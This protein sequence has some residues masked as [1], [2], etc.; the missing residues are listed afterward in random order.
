MIDRDLQKHA[1]EFRG[2]LRNHKYDVTDDGILFP[3]AGAMAS[4]E[5]FFDTDGERPESS[6]NLIPSAA[7]EYILDVALG[8]TAAQPAWY[9]ALYSG[10]YTPVAGLTAASFS[11]SA[12]EIVSAVEGYSEVTRR[13][14]NA[15]PAAGGAKD[16]V[17][18]RAAFSIKTAGSITI[19][20]AALVS[21]S[22]K[23]G[24]S[25]ILVSAS[26]FTND[27]VE[28]DG[29]VFNLGYR[30]RIRSE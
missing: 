24:T 29:N 19:R 2:Y 7:L 23:G 20:G 8:A 10:A 14:W 12:T 5:Y 17:A 18:D 1:A 26:R 25:G 11:S 15:D 4:G 27:R 30:A 21:S 3:K 16:N 13:P 28:Y 22:T 6:H 9:L